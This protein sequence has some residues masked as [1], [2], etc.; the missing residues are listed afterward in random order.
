MTIL[1]IVTIVIFAVIG[2][3]VAGFAGYYAWSTKR[4]FLLLCSALS[5]ISKHQSEFGNISKDECVPRAIELANAS[6][7]DDIERFMRSDE[8]VSTYRYSTNDFLV[9]TKDGDIR[10][11]FKPKNGKI[12]WGY[13]HERNR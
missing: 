5:I 1:S 6:L 4:A 2:L 8:S 7:S 10:T 11:F 12:Y 9:M 3:V 13:E